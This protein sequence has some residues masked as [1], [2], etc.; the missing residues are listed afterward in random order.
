MRAR[1]I[2]PTDDLGFTGE[3]EVEESIVEDP[4]WSI[5]EGPGPAATARE[6]PIA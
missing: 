1:R 5:L 6:E 2:V 3:A 4:G